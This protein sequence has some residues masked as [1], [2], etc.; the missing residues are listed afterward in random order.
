MQT[1]KMQELLL[2][3][4]LYMNFLRKGKEWDLWFLD[5]HFLRQS[6]LLVLFEADNVWAIFTAVDPAQPSLIGIHVY[7]DKMEK[8]QEIPDL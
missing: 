8:I 4:E 2:L 7:Q 1:V 5:A 6:L 3:Y